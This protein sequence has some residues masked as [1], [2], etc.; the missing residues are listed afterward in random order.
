MQLFLFKTP[1]FILQ[2]NREG[3]DNKIKSICNFLLSLTKEY[4]WPIVLF[5][6]EYTYAVN[7]IILLLSLSLKT[8]T[9]TEFCKNYYSLYKSLTNKN[10]GHV[11]N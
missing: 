2:I 7:V 3:K 8:H 9:F 10:H 1:F 6:K 11:P 4:F 5:N